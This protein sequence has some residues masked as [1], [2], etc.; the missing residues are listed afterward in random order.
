MNLGDIALDY[1]DS[2][3]IVYD[4]DREFIYVADFKTQQNLQILTVF[5]IKEVLPKPSNVEWLFMRRRIKN[6][7]DVK[8]YV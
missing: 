8:E 7:V 1:N 2:Q 6:L 4:I 5:E 3:W